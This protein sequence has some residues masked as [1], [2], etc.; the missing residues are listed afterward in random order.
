MA[1]YVVVQTSSGHFEV[2]ETGMITSGS[3]HRA[4]GPYYGQP[5]FSV[6]G[7]QSTIQGDIERLIQE[8]R[9]SDLFTL[10]DLVDAKDNLTAQAVVR[11]HRRPQGFNPIGDSD[12]IL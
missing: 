6:D 10:R 9:P 12:K 7:D 4:P 5:Y 2:V 3:G 8:K 1:N 11:E